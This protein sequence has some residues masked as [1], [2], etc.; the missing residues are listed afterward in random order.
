MPFGGQDLYKAQAVKEQA[1]V[2]AH[3]QAILAEAGLPGSTVLTC[4]PPALYAGLVVHG[5]YARA[6]GRRSVGKR[7]RW[8][9]RMQRTYAS[10]ERVR[11]KMS[12]PPSYLLYAAG[13]PTHPG[14][15]GCGS[16]PS[17]FCG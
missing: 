5:R 16:L 1:A 13:A 8:R 3:V 7:L 15:N 2:E 12:E 9:A 14:S 10:S 17:D 6:R 4:P 11:L